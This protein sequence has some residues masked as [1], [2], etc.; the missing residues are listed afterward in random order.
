M[1][2]NEKNDMA[3]VGM[4]IDISLRKELERELKRQATKDGLTGINNR[5]NQEEL[6]DKEIERAK[7]FYLCL[8]IIM[9]D[10]DHFKKINDTFGHEVGDDVLKA[11]TGETSKILRDCDQFGRWGGE[12]FLILA[13]QSDLQAANILANRIH[14]AIANIPQI[15]A[16]FGVGQYQTQENLKDFVKRVDEAMYKAKRAGRNQVMSST[17]SDLTHHCKSNEK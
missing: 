9:F 16:S 11:V 13:I 7:R 3:I 1:D 6:L 4:G 8:S 12:E 10:I 17:S 2:R 14:T 5:P 15:T